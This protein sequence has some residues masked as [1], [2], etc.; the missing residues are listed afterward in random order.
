M[1]LNHLAGVAVDIDRFGCSETE[2]F[3][4]DVLGSDFHLKRVLQAFVS[5]ARHP[6]Q[7]VLLAKF[8]FQELLRYKTSADEDC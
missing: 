7:D 1:V 4:V 8:A 5:F 6:E 3:L 2:M